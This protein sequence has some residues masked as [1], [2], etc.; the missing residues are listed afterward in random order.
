MLIGSGTENALFDDIDL[1]AAEEELGF[2][3]DLEFIA[4]VDEMEQSG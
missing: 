1:L 2:Y 4:W 3:E